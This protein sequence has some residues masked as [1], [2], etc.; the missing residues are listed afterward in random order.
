MQGDIFQLEDILRHQ[1]QDP[2]TPPP[3]AA[4]AI[5][6]YYYDD[7][8]ESPIISVYNEDDISA[9]LFHGI[10]PVASFHQDDDAVQDYTPVKT[11]PVRDEA[12]TSTSTSQAHYLEAIAGAFDDYYTDAPSVI[13]A[14]TT[15]TP[16]KHYPRHKSTK[17]NNNI[18]FSV[19]QY[20]S[21]DEDECAISTDD[22]DN[23]EDLYS[24]SSSGS[25]NNGDPVTRTANTSR[26][27]RHF[28]THHIGSPP[29]S[30]MPPVRPV[31]DR[32]RDS[33]AAAE[34]RR[35]QALQQ[36]GAAAVKAAA[37]FAALPAEQ[38]VDHIEGPLMSW[39]P[40]PVEQLEFDWNERFY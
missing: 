3:K 34:A 26:P 15:A 25:S 10:S 1:A 9:Y 22:E 5:R 16:A 31:L 30:D 17:N 29:G 21:D 24:N 39:W 6:H 13:L 12:P 2:I 8:A 36:P 37:G 18:R 32:K 27:C 14:D 19:Y 38:H 11:A 33:A 35:S 7:E 28:H 4:L 20:H 40:L 23:D